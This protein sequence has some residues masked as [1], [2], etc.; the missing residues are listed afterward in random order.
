[1]ERVLNEIKN[2][3]S[4]FENLNLLTKIY[5]S[6]ENKFNNIK[7]IFNINCINFCSKCC[8]TNVNNIQ[9]TI[10]ELLIPAIFFYEL[11]FN[12]NKEYIE[13]LFQLYKIDIS[14]E[15]LKSKIVNFIFSNNINLDR[16]LFYNNQEGKWGCSIYNIRPS[17][18]R[19]F[20]FSLVKDKF[21]NL[22][23]SPCKELKEFLFYNKNNKDKLINYNINLNN[24][25]DKINITNF[26][27]IDNYYNKI[28]KSNLPIYDKLYQEV[29]TLNYQYTKNLYNINEAFKKAFE[30]IY[31]KFYMF[32]Y[33]NIS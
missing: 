2:K 18:C 9:A 19:L 28:S 6:W 7:N 8:D 3:I 17:I 13:D 1:M 15:I 29:L 24:M 21:G 30:I 12:K 5:E 25:N 26:L 23:F 20:G 16:C 4:F 32:E 33:N 10:F 27:R 31:L 14:E 11:I 22:N